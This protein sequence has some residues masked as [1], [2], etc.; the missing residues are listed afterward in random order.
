MKNINRVGIVIG[1]NPNMIEMY[2]RVHMHNN[3]GVRD[4]LQKYNIHNFSIFIRKLDDGKEYLFGYY[5]YTGDDYDSDM[6][7][8]AAEPRNQEWLSLCGPCQITLNDE[9]SWAVMEE[10]YHNE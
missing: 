3:P 2:R 10:I 5:E 7:K 6:T 4:L 9:K 1:T 8:L